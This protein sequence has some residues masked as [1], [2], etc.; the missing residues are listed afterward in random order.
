MLKNDR[1]KEWFSHP[2]AI[3][4]SSFITLIL[5]GRERASACTCHG[6]KVMHTLY[7]SPSTGEASPPPSPVAGEGLVDS[8]GRE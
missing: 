8:E 2:P 1:R 5:S 7:S 6:T 3:F 4:Y